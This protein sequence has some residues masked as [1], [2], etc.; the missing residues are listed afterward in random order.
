M[1][2]WNEIKRSMKGGI[3]EERKKGVMTGK[4]RRNEKGVGKEKKRKRGGGKT[5]NCFPS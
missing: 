5:K 1:K 2:I 4:G 3:K